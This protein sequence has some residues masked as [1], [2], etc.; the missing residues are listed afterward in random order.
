MV[1][2]RKWILSHIHCV[3]TGLRFR[4]WAGE[5]TPSQQ[6]RDTAVLYRLLFS[7]S[8]RSAANSF[9]TYRVPLTSTQFRSWSLFT[10]HDPN[11]DP[12]WPAP[13]SSAAYAPAEA[14]VVR[15][16]RFSQRSYIPCMVP[17][18]YVYAT[19]VQFDVAV[20]NRIMTQALLTWIHVGNSILSVYKPRRF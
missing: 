11:T 2:Q 10:G 13:G 6:R 14:G 20:R 8:W 12:L 15:H 5:W 1:V 7:Y 16:G 4:D 9:Y 3:V 19:F 18:V 17:S